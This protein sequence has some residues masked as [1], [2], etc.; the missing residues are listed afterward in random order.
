[1]RRQAK[2]KKKKNTKSL[3]TVLLHKGYITKGTGFSLRVFW[4][5]FSSLCPKPLQPPRH[6]ALLKGSDF[7]NT[8][9]VTHQRTLCAVHSQRKITPS[10]LTSVTH[11]SFISS[12]KK[13]KRCRLK[14]VTYKTEKK[15]ILKQGSAVFFQYTLYTHWT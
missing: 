2:K 3:A 6:S 15:I 11:F 13:S 4:L 7:K 9:H 8:L 1:M 12:L 14:D 5:F 10:E